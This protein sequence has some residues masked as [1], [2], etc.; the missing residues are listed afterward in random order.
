MHAQGTG[1]VGIGLGTKTMPKSDIILGYV[2]DGTGKVVIEDRYASDN[3]LPDTDVSLGYADDITNINGSQ[4]SGVTVL[5]F[6]R[7][8]KTGDP[9]DYAIVEGT[10]APVIFAFSTTD[11][12][13]YHGQDNRAIA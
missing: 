11:S 6:S 4:I 7:L 10:A 3:A 9:L 5:I 2:E 8:L 12:L 1:W 13:G